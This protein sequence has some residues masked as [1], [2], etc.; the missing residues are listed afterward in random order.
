MPAK[1]DWHALE[2]KWQKKW[3][4]RKIHETDPD[5]R[6]PKYY[7][8]AAYPYPNYPKHIGHARTYTIDDVNARYHRMIGYI[9]HIPIGCQYN[10][11][12]LFTTSKIILEGEPKS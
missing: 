9:T 6:K 4:W 8:T 11:Y 2:R 12:Q 10:R 5:P 1:L 3:N 7:V